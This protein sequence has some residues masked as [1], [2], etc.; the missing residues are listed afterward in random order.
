MRGIVLAP[1]EIAKSN[2]SG[3][4]REERQV[5]RPD[6]KLELLVSTPSWRGWLSVTTSERIGGNLGLASTGTSLVATK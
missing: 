1:R 6:Q 5:V 4:R 3:K 2:S